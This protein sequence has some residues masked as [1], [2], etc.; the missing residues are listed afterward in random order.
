MNNYSREKIVS[1]KYLLYK[2][3][4]RLWLVVLVAAIAFGIGYYTSAKA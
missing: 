3:V 4:K 2:L 1:L